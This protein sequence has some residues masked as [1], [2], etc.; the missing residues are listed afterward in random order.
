MQSFDL[1]LYEL[2]KLAFNLKI[3]YLK[4]PQNKINCKQKAKVRE[5][6]TKI[7]FTFVFRILDFQ[8]EFQA[9]AKNK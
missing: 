3:R 9:H 2:P 8:I 4:I 1:F 6:L 7:K 5:R